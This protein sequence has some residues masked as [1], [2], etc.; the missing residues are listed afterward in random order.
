[1]REITV[2]IKLEDSGKVR[3]FIE[4]VTKELEE[5]DYEIQRL[6]EQVKTNIAQLKEDG[7]EV[8]YVR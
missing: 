5:K 4:K 7:I 6:E 3:E 2:N 1:M 8:E